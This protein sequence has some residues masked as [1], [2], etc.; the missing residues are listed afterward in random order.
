M[1]Y[2]ILVG[3]QDG[4]SKVGKSRCMWEYNIKM[5]FREI[6]MWAVGT[7]FICLRKSPKE[8]SFSTINNLRISK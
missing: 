4:K 3:I 8:M 7:G 6:G 1:R 5:D 2:K